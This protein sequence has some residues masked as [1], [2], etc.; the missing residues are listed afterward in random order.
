MLAVVESIAVARRRGRGPVRANTASCGEVEPNLMA[1]AMSGDRAAFVSM[2]AHYDRLLRLVAWQVLG[3]RD[4][5]D[6]ALQEVALKAWRSLSGFRGEAQLGTWLGR[7]AYN[8]SVDL[9]RRRPAEM[10]LEAAAASA[11]PLWADSSSGADPAETIAS[12]AALRAAFS[13]LTVEQRLT[14]MLVD[15]EGYDYETVAAVLGVRPGTIASRLHRAHAG[16]RAA[17][18]TPVPGGEGR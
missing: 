18:G 17:L 13:S 4:L 5:M 12:Q 6:D 8:A 3:D 1:A 15:R 11:L 16:L 9:L 10:A 14:V 2:L 7:L